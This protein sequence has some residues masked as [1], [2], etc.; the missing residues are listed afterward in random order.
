MNN[1]AYKL[2]KKWVFVGWVL[3]NR[4]RILRAIDDESHFEDFNEIYDEVAEIF[5]EKETAEV[6]E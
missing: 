1:N 2:T 3:N 5:E 4:N 6:S